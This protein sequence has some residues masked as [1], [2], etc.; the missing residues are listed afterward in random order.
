MRLKLT[1]LFAILSLFFFCHADKESAAVCSG[2]ELAVAEPINAELGDVDPFDLSYDLTSEEFSPAQSIFDLAGCRIS[3]NNIPVTC[4]GERN[5]ITKRRNLSLLLFVKFAVANV[6]SEC[7][8]SRS[9]NFPFAHQ[10]QKNLFFSLC[11]IRI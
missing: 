3:S 11:N 2:V 8:Y 6:Y 4:V 5:N 1:I 10:P 9:C 7:S